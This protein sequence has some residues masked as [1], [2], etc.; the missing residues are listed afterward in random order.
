MNWV[1]KSQRCWLHACQI[2]Q[3]EHGC[4]G[5][6]YPNKFAGQL[7]VSGR[8]LFERAATTKCNKLQYTL[9]ASKLLYSAQALQSL[10]HTRDSKP[11]GIPAKFKHQNV[12]SLEPRANSHA[13]AAQSNYRAA[14]TPLSLQQRQT[15]KISKRFDCGVHAMLSACI[16]PPE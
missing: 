5:K 13:A 6:R 16:C 9:Q 15:D 2:A 10:L 7:Y 11:T 4:V 1:S 8:V 14:Q 3:I 12:R